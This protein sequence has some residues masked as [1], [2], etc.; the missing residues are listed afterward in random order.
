MRENCSIKRGKKLKIHI[1]G[2]SGKMGREIENLAR[3]DSSL[4][5]V[6]KEMDLVID[7]STPEGTKKAL[8]LKKPLVCG[9]TGLSDDIFDEMKKLSKYVPICYS[10]NF[11][12]GIALFFEI[13]EQFKEKIKKYAR[14]KIEETHHVQKR[15]RPS[16]TALKM[17]EILGVEYKNID[18]R[19]IDDVVGM[20]QVNFLFD[21]ER[22]QLLSEVASRKAFARGALL[23]A[24]FI[25][26]KKPRF[27]TLKDIFS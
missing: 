11:S 24:K 4:E 21:D 3:E 27:Y 2:L 1:I 18:S 9:T 16:G 23:A 12:L 8:L 25:F 17:A 22:L 13:L 26:Q 10:P 5:I 19:R 14:I 6:E 15:D 7:F 20:H